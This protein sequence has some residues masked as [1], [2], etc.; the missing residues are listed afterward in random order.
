MNWEGSRG[1]LSN[2]VQ[3]PELPSSPLI[4]LVVIMLL[5]NPHQMIQSQYVFLA[6]PIFFTGLVVCWDTCLSKMFCLQDFFLSP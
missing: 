4:Y 6:A 1:T 3:L 2:P 5:V